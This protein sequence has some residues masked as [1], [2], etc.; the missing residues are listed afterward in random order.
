MRLQLWTIYYPP[1]QLGIGPVAG[2]WAT[3]MRGRGHSVQV[4]TAHP[5]YPAPAWGRSWRP[6]RALE[7]GVD[8]IRLPVLVRRDTAKRRMLQE[9]SFTLGLLAAGPLLDKPDVMVVVSPS[10]PALSAAI[11]ISRA[12]RIPWVLWLQDMVADAA[13][14]TALVRSRA[15]LSMAQRLESAAYRSAARIVV[16]S[17]AFR[18]NLRNKG[19][20]EEKITTIHNPATLPNLDHPRSLNGGNRVINI[21]NLGRS[22]GLPRLVSAFESSAELR[23]LDAR[24]VIT[25]GGVA[26]EEVRNVI[27]TDR[28]E[29]LG[30][31]PRERLMREIDGA[32]IGIVSQRPGLVEFN[33]PSKL[34]NYMARGLPVV[35][36][37]DPASETARLIRESGAGWVTDPDDLDQFCDT[38]ARVL[39]DPGSRAGAS[40]AGLRFAQRTLGPSTCAA[41]FEKIALD[42]ADR[43]RSPTGSKLI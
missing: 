36:S 40:A 12:R 8:V 28:V 6:H 5:H 9:A 2:S 29:C 10:L 11:M 27:T 3:V 38:L 7:G 20:P 22:Q 43:S 24:L 34:M 31:V 35:A 37:V 14:A 21:G 25:G 30:I 32:S 41:Q 18:A 16:V 39:A 42:L 13:F 23:R 19:I 1:V 17:D 15:V 26:S 4:V 33:L